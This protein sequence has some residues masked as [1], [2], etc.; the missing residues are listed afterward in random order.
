MRGVL[1]SVIGDTE[2]VFCFPLKPPD[3]DSHNLTFFPGL[4]RLPS[5]NQQMP[6]AEIMVPSPTELSRREASVCH[7]FNE[8]L[9]CK[10]P[11]DQKFHELEFMSD[12][13]RAGTEYLSFGLAP[14]A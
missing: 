13:S 7:A 11:G 8:E 2:H 5:K 12:S 3:C 4:K 14:S 6:S 9:M 10:G 1:V